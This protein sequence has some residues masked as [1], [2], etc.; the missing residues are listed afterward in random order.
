MLCIISGT[1][2]GEFRVF[3]RE[4]SFQRESSRALKAVI[5]GDSKVSAGFVVMLAGTAAVD[6]RRGVRVKREKFGGAAC[7]F[8]RRRACARTA[9]IG[10]GR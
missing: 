4:L 2:L 5:N 6:A 8:C 7:C 10:L 1:S 9:K 3:L